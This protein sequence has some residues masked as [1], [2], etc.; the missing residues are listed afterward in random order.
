[1]PSLDRH[2]LDLVSLGLDP[3][4]ALVP[5]SHPLAGSGPVALTA[6]REESWILPRGPACAALVRRACLTAGFDSTVALATDDHAAARSLAASNLG[7]AV[8]PRLMRQRSG[9]GVAVLELDPAPARAVFAAVAGGGA[10]PPAAL[11]LRDAFVIT[12][13]L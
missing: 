6:L 5:E 10:A 9:D 2:G 4:D 7:V 3:M 1:V 8:L 13:R 11:A 12:T